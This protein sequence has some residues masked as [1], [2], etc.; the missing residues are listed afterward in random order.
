MVLVPELLYKVGQEERYIYIYKKWER[1]FH[2][3]FFRKKT[4]FPSG[5]IL[6][7]KSYKL[8]ESIYY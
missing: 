6:Q 8:R 5:E 7:K 4:P 3:T 2:P 1:Q